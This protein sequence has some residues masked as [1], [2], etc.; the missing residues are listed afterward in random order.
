MTCKC[1]VTLRQ[2]VGSGFSRSD[3]AMATLTGVFLVWS[4][5]GT[6]H[7]QP[8]TNV[9]SAL[10]D[11]SHGDV[12]PRTACASLANFKDKEIAHLEARDVPAS[13]NAPAHCRV[14]GILTPEIAFEVNLPARW[15]RRFYMIGNGGHAGEA[16]DDPRRT[17]QRA[18]ALQHGF[19]MAQTN[20]GHD[21][22]KEPQASFVLSNPQKAIDYAYRAV[23]LTA[24]TAK[25][26]AN[27]YYSKPVA[28]SYWNSCSN[29]GR[30]GLIEAQRYPDDFD[31]IV[32]NAPWVEQ[33]G[34]TVG[35][36]WNQRALTD[37][38]ISR[39]KLAL[40]AER[41][42]A[43]CD[44]IDGLADGLIDDPRRCDFDPARDVPSCGTG[45]DSAQCLTPAEATTLNKIYGGVI[46][47][48][49][50]FFPAFMYGSE[51]MSS[52]PDGTTNSGW[53]NAIIPREAD[54]KPADFSLAESTMKYLVFREPKPDY[55]FRTFDF[56][57]D[58]DQL[59]RWGKLAN[60]NNPDLSGFRKRG[61]KLLMTYGW[62]DPV[63]MPMMGVNY[64]ERA[65]SVNGPK[66]T[67]FFRLF[68]I[69][70]MAHCGGGVGPDQHD[71]VTAV[72]DWVEKGKAPDSLIASK[73]VNNQVVRTRPLCPYPQVARYKGNGSVDDAANFSCVA[74]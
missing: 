63:L 38:P 7:A 37:A 68:M 11:Y 65:L 50:P 19:V 72:I 71:P 70:G 60:A 57:R 61:G 27:E 42:M 18:S 73:V 3:F 43:K 4:A 44:R 69:P 52:G 51:A 34:F 64:Y 25:R 24:T 46:S 2:L 16:L 45:A 13:D 47:N 20:T 35:A 15:N 41:V 23:H 67:D 10:V 1:R 8:F 55:D 31:G 12:D 30:Q 58:V 36:L 22:L 59:E 29:G 74:P 5:V 48:G 53:M 33:T 26:V 17:V 66:T 54:V 32:A 62:A 40:V 6:A 56:D 39:P 28:Y 9:K 49:K 14:S 21:A